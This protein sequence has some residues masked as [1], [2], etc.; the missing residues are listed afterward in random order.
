MAFPSLYVDYPHLTGANVTHR[1]APRVE[2][3]EPEQGQLGWDRSD[4]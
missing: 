1:R 3:A 2:P 4:A